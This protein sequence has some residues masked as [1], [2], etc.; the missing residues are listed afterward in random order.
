M[1]SHL[2][3]L[4]FPNRCLGC[5]IFLKQESGLCKQCAA[6]IQ[7]N[8]AFV[9]SICRSR[10]PLPKPLCHKNSPFVLASVTAYGPIIALVIRALKYKY[11]RHLLPTL[12]TLIEEY[13][14]TL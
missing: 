7:I 5:R 3:E 10:S 12:T 11:A 2:F 9:C 1:I 6:K 13:L 4:L 14:R 8:S